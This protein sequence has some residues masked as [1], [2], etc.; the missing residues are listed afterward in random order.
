MPYDLGMRR[1]ALAVPMVGVAA[2]LG[3]G[4][5]AADPAQGCAVNLQAP[6]VV[7]SSGMAAVVASVRPGACNRAVPQLQV[8]CLQQVGSPVAPLCVQSEGPGAAEVRVTPYTPGAGYTVSGR[9]CANAG[10]PAVTYCNTVGP[11]TVTL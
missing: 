3:T 7:E 4:P 9:V 1:L 8:A 10:S 11:T 5:A 2:L 6:A